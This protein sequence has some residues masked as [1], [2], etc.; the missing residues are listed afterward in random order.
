MIAQIHFNAKHHSQDCFKSFVQYESMNYKVYKVNPLAIV[1]NRWI[2]KINFIL[3]FR[4]I[5]GF[6]TCMPLEKF[7]WIMANPTFN[8]FVRIIDKIIYSWKLYIEIIRTWCSSLLPCPNWRRPQVKCTIKQG[9]ESDRE[10]IG[11]ER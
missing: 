5:V 3:Q 4:W 9:E 6:V 11:E 10:D 1:Y 7:L 2:S 8:S